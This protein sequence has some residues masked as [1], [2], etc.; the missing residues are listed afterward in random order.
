MR[1]LATT[2]LL[3]VALSAPAAPADTLI[4]RCGA[5]DGG[6]SFLTSALDASEIALTLGGDLAPP[7]SDGATL[8]LRDGEAPGWSAAAPREI[9]ADCGG[10]GTPVIDIFPV[11]RPRDGVW[12]A[13]ITGTEV[14]GCP[15]AAAAG[16]AGAAGA[17]NSTTIAWPEPFNPAPLFSGHA[18]FRQT[19]LMR[20][21]GVLDRQDSDT[22][23]SSVIVYVTARSETR[24]EGRSV[25]TLRFAP[26]LAQ[27]MG[28]SET[29]HAVTTAVYEWQD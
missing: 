6:A 25:M 22:V 3:A 8:V 14:T 12:Q 29:C 21:R 28:G 20:W 26:M 27:M 13:Q 24:M 19:G 10:E 15:A 5:G 11:F 23:A 18:T 7:P 17:A 1:L 2:G 4:A 16:A 9:H